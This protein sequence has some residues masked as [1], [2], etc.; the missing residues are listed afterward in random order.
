MK[1]VQ[2][3]SNFS[4][5]IFNHFNEISDLYS[6]RHITSIL[7]STREEEREKALRSEERGLNNHNHPFL[8]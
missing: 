6:A 2:N 5:R 3:I 1:D 8:G 7:G 4:I